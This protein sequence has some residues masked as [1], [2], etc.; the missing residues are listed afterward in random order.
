[1]GVP[2]NPLLLLPL[3]LPFVV[4]GGLPSFMNEDDYKQCDDQSCWWTTFDI[5]FGDVDV[6]VG[7]NMTVSR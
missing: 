1:M 6:K 5:V 4:A 2:D 7:I 3:L